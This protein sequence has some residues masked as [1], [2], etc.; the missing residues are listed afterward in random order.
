MATWKLAPAW[1]A[2]CPVVLKTAP[3]TPLSALRLAEL[4]I[5]AGFPPGVLNVLSGSDE[6]G[7]LLVAHPDVDKVAFTGSTAVGKLIRQAC[8][9]SPRFKR[10]SLE[11]GGKSPMIV[12]DDA[13]MDRALAIAQLGLFLN[14]GQACCASSRIMVHKSRYDE[15]CD[16]AASLANERFVGPGWAHQ[17]ADPAPG[18]PP[19]GPQVD[20]AQMDQILRY[21]QSGKDEGAELLA[22]GGRIGDKGYFVQP[23]VFGGVTDDMTIA[24]EEIFGPV[25]QVMTYEDDEEAVVRANA[26]DYGLATAIVATEEAA[27]RSMAR[28][29]KAG[30]VWIN[31]YDVLEAPLSFGG[32][33][34]A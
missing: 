2:G 17:A 30:T 4:A 20:E 1:A 13:N 15:F 22:G 7:R 12:R 31:A 3:Q 25:M 10:V 27:A 8:A 21:V 28:R 19:Q 32:F 24:K 11:L 23:T 16:R 33:K 34:A 6:T 9:E 14:A 18:A 26:T 29:I 5:E